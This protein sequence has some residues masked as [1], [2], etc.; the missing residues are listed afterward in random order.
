MLVIADGA[1]TTKL[2][3]VARAQL[4]VT[5]SVR[6]LADAAGGPPPAAV[7][8]YC[9]ATSACGATCRSVHETTAPSPL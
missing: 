9:V 7:A 6:S 8:T 4:A 2:G 1:R 3:A 5:A